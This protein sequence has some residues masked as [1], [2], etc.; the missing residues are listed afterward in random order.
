VGIEILVYTYC[1]STNAKEI[2][3]IPAWKPPSIKA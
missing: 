2:T 3:L 1:T